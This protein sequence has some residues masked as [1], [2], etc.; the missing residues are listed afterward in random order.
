[1]KRALPVSPLSKASER[2]G[3]LSFRSALS[4]GLFF[5]SSSI[6]KGSSRSGFG[7]GLEEPGN[8]ILPKSSCGMPPAKK[9]YITFKKVMYET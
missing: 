1:M 2:G 3:F 5:I 8:W 7:G 4:C 9:I 6:T